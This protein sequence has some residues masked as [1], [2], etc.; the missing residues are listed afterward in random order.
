[1]TEVLPV[2]HADATPPVAVIGGDGDPGTKKRDCARCGGTGAVLGGR[3]QGK[4]CRAEGC[5]AFARFCE[6]RRAEYLTPGNVLRATD[7]S[8]AVQADGS[9][10]RLPC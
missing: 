2:A 5:R 10:R 1:M 8:Y 7:R 4:R 9:I 3:H 6:R